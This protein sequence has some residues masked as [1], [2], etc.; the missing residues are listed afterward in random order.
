MT[1]DAD[2]TRFR[3]YGGWKVGIY[4]MTPWQKKC[5]E[6][7]EGSRAIL[8]PYSRQKEW[9]SGETLFLGRR[10]PLWHTGAETLSCQWSRLY[11]HVRATLT[12][13]TRRGVSRARVGFPPVTRE[14]EYP[15]GGQT[16][17]APEAA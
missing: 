1:E 8:D 14:L 7:L 12:A 11:A 13:P 5:P 9:A 16:L 17:E 15:L 6:A 2:V 10:V 4:R 3:V